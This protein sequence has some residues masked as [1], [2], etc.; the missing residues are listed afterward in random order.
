MINSKQ[1]LDFLRKCTKE[2]L[3]YL[4]E[5]CLYIGVLLAEPKTM[6]RFINDY[7]SNKV[8]NEE[9]KEYKK[10]TELLEKASCLI[11]PYKDFSKVPQDTVL[12]YLKTLDEAEGVYKKAERLRI[13]YYNLTSKSLE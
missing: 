10:F 1:D 11:K 13:R 7:R 2:E 3:I 4:I 5:H 8:L 6:E 9:E 12:R